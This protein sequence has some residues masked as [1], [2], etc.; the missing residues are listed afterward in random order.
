MPREVPEWIGVTDDTPIP[1]K[2]QLRV[3]RRYKGICQCGCGIKIRGKSW[4]IDHRIALINGGQNRETN[5]VPML[6]EHHRKKTCADVAQ[7]KRNY[8]RQLAH[9]GI[10]PRRSRPIPGSKGSGIRR[11]MDGTVWRES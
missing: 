6:V 2:V 11:R 10:K 4:D 8:R 5:L 7:K 9:A 1:P 3:F